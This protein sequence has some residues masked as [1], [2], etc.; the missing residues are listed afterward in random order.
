MAFAHYCQRLTALGLLAF[1]HKHDFFADPS[2]L[3]VANNMKTDHKKMRVR[4]SAILIKEKKMA[5]L[6]LDWHPF[7][8]EVGSYTSI[9]F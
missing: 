8:S 9:L 5:L 2:S 3:I 7:E 1:L 6:E 4:T